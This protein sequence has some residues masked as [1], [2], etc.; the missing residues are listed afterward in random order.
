MQR[1]FDPVTNRSQSSAVIVRSAIFARQELGDNPFDFV[2]RNPWPLARTHVSQK[3]KPVG[4]DSLDIYGGV[5][6]LG[7]PKPSSSI[8]HS[9][10]G[11]FIQNHPFW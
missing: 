9:I 10:E 8:I 1:G 11:S 2:H 3:K 5:R 7:Y 4:F 6:E